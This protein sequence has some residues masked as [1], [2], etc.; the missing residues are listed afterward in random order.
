[1]FWII[2]TIVLYI[3]SL[4][5]C[6]FLFIEVNDVYDLKDVFLILAMSIFSPIILIALMFYIIK[7]KIKA[8]KR[9]KL[10]K[11]LSDREE[12]LKSEVTE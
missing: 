7:Y 2:A 8:K 10:K 5:Y 9:K 6:C 12:S 3:T 4:M 11:T 1:M